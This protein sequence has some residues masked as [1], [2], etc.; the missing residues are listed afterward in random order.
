LGLLVHFQ[1]T[2]PLEA[3]LFVSAFIA[4]LAITISVY[5]ARRYLDLRSF[6]SLGLGWRMQSLGDLL[7]GV[8]LSGLLM[9]L[10]FLI[11]WAVAGCD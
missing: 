6:T 2:F 8:G 7:C 9:G 11:E 4:F 1:P 5:L 3:T 10:V